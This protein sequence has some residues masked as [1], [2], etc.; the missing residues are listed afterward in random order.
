MTEDGGLLKKIKPVYSFVLG[1]AAAIG[2]ERLV[3]Y[4]K[5]KYDEGRK[6]E[7]EELV[8]SIVKRYKEERMT[9]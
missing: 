2:G 8:E 3:Y 1:A 7:T 9:G 6:R 4:I 5:G